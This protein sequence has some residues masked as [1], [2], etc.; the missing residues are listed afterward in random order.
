MTTFETEK[1]A[2]ALVVIRLP[3]LKQFGCTN[4]KNYVRK[5]TGKA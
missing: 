1:S 2:L 3:N 4:Y 5:F